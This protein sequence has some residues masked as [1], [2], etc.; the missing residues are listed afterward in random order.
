VADLVSKMLTAL[1]SQ[2]DA[3]LLKARDSSKNQKSSEVRDQEYWLES[4]ITAM[5]K[6]ARA[7]R[8]GHRKMASYR[9][10]R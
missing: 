6:V 1:L 7:G 4:E 2:K 3:Q 8:W 9:H 5:M 10:E